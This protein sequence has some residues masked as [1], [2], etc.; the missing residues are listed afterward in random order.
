MIGYG[1]WMWQASP[2]CHRLATNTLIL[3]LS[4]FFH[5]YF[6]LAYLILLLFYTAYQISD[7][8]CVFDSNCQKYIAYQI[9]FNEMS[10]LAAKQ[11][12]TL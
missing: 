1:S 5:A 10:D 11:I 3:S 8:L 7:C 9:S 6:T 12:Q 4:T 2:P